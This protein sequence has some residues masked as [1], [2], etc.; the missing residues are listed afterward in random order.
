M[1]P[2]MIANINQFQKENAENVDLLV[3]NRH[4]ELLYDSRKPHVDN[5]QEVIEKEE[6]RALR[7][8]EIIL[9]GK[10]LYQIQQNM[11]YRANNGIYPPTKN[12]VEAAKTAVINIAQLIG[13]NTGNGMG[14]NSGARL[15]MAM[16]SGLER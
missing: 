15:N 2:K 3:L 10:Q 16:A 5:V 1:L 9:I 4:N 14:P 6:N 11:L 12:E 7:H 8:N 13:E